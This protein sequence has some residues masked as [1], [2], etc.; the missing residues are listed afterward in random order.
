MTHRIFEAF[1]IIVIVVSSIQLGLISPL[2]DPNGRMMDILYWID[3]AT[4]MIFLIECIMK[5]IAFGFVLNGEPSYLRNPWNLVDF[6]IIVF[7]VISISPLAN[8]L[9]IIK[10]FRVLRALRLISRAEG[11]KIGLQALV[12][13]IPNVIR[14]VMIMLLFFVLFGVIAISYFK[15]RF[16]SCEN[17]AVAETIPDMD[18]IFVI[19]YKWDCINA[20]GEWTREYYTFDNM[21]K[22]MASLFIISNI[23]GWQ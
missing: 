15:G 14:I 2:N 21:Y 1:I 17:D 12:Q 3:F 22:T 11:L 8:Q 23:V 18:S 6:I 20:G 16:Y 4:T 19:K 13:A 10:M 9:K 5:I 7:S